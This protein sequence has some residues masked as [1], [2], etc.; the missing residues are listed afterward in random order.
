MM[1][2]GTTENYKRELEQNGYD[3]L[4]V[5]EDSSY[6]VMYKKHYCETENDDIISIIHY[7][8]ES[9]YWNYSKFSREELHKL[10]DCMNTI[11]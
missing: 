6:V 4:D 2:F 9:D 1:R 7:E 8:P 3:V 10:F 11:K 5:D